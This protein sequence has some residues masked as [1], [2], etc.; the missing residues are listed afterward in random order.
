[1]TGPVSLAIGVFD[2]VHLGHQAVIG[3]ALENA[4]HHG[5]EAV[6]VTFDP[7]PA[8]VI[9]PEQSPKML[10]SVGHKLGIMERLGVRNALVCAFDEAFSRVEARAF[11][12]SIV[13]ACERLAFV[14]VGFTW[15]FGH[16]GS[17]DIHLLADLGQELG[18]CVHGVPPV[19]VGGE[20]VSSTLIRD[21]VAAGDFSRASLLLGREYAVAGV[22]ARGEQLGRRIGFPTANVDVSCEQLPPPGVY[23]VRAFVDGRARA[24]VAN[25]GR[26]PTVSQSAELALEAHLLDFEGDLYGREMEIAFRR[27]LRDEKKFDGLAELKAQIARDVE[28]A[29]E[30]FATRG[31]GSPLSL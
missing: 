19:R 28:A 5:G 13:A 25:L 30:V 24:A 18:F 23:A 8:R 16:R 7:H 3:A 4:A 29:R 20:V 9:R 10:C 26:R 6:V 1:V 22:V 17:G 31:H 12:Q 2:G 15:R 11:V 14:S 27:K 21:A